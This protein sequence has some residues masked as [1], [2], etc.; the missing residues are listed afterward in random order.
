ME[1]KPHSVIRQALCDALAA[2]DRANDACGELDDCEG[3]PAA[4]GEMDCA[5]SE[6]RDLLIRRVAQMVEEE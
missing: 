4:R 1:D 5:V 3:C 6:I 2:L